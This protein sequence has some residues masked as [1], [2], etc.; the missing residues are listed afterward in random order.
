MTKEEFIG[1]VM[2]RIQD[3]Y[4]SSQAQRFIERVIREETEQFLGDIKEHIIIS[5]NV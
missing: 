4:T 3:R 1:N 2:R 5:V